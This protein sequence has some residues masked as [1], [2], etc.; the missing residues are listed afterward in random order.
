[1]DTRFGH[2]Q[3]RPLRRFAIQQG[4]KWRGIDDAHDSG[5]NDA[6]WASVRVHTTEPAWV[7]AV[8]RLYY[9]NRAELERA[10]ARL[11]ETLHLEGG[12]DD[13]RSAYR[14]KPVHES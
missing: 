5:H 14:W 8:A 9:A 4:E 3:W 11:G 1:M 6:Q 7:A 10:A 2:G 13:E 12:T